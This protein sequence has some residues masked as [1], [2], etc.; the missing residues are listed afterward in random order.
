MKNL[1]SLIVIFTGIYPA[2]AQPVAPPSVRPVAPPS[3]SVKTDCLCTV[4]K[5]VCAPA[6][7]SCPACGT[8]SA[9]N[10]VYTQASGFGSS[11][12]GVVVWAEDG[13]SLV[14]TNKHVVS[15][16]ISGTVA[17]GGKTYPCKFVG[18]SED[19][20]VALLE[21][22]VTLPYAKM[23]EKNAEPG[24]VVTHYGN[25][26]GPQSGTVRFY[27]ETTAPLLGWSGPSMHSTYVSDSGDSGAGVYNTDGK[28]VAIHWGGPTGSKQAAPVSTVRRLLGRFAAKRFTG[29][30]AQLTEA[31]KSPDVVKTPPVV[32]PAAT[33][34]VPTATNLV[35]YRD[36]RTGAYYYTLPSCANGNCPNPVSR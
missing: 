27:V 19:G 3:I 5:C 21:V 36:P 1:L 22:A 12:S 30:S 2:G 34:S 23:S 25:S 29:L 24:M 26:T 28:L 4:N 32:T 33:A 9:V 6:S 31:E 15:N 13:V 20:D 16:G 18:W 7:C 8:R 10:V 14:V 11:G 35:R 17:H